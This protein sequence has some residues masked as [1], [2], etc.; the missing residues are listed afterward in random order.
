[1]AQNR[2]A[3]ALGTGGAEGV[4]LEMVDGIGRGHVKSGLKMAGIHTLPIL[5]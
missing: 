1:M 5:R 4:V 2:R 3:V